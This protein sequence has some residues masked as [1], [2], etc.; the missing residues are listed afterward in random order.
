MVLDVGDILTAETLFSWI[1]VAEECWNLAHF[2]LIVASH[3]QSFGHP[4]QEMDLVRIEVVE[5]SALQPDVSVT[6]SHPGHSHRR[7]VG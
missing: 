4:D 1:S 5:Q 7:T 6:H 3:H 2:T